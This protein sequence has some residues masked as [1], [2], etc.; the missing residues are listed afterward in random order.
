M[1][2][3]GHMATVTEQRQAFIRWASYQVIPGGTLRTWV[4]QEGFDR[5]Q[6]SLMLGTMV[7]E[8]LVRPVGPL[9]NEQ[10]KTYR[11]SWVVTDEGHAWA[12]DVRAES[13][14]PENGIKEV[15]ARART[16]G[17]WT[18]LPDGTTPRER[19]LIRDRGFEIGF[20]IKSQEG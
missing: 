11:K 6:F 4:Q 15:E 18:K 10:G 17:K 5:W 8:G 3:D 13:A 20:F 7:R 12:Q 16:T 14:D 1:A 19:V 9:Q 2:Y